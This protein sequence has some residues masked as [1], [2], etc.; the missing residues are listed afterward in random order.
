MRSN[1]SSRPPRGPDLPGRL[2]AAALLLLLAAACPAP[3]ADPA[4]DAPD[5]GAQAQPP[6][7]VQTEPVRRGT[8]EETVRGTATVEAR[9]QL[10][11][12][13][14]SGGTL[15]RVLVEEGDAVQPGQL[16]AEIDNPDLALTRSNAAHLVARLKRELAD[17]EP[18]VAKGYAPRQSAD[19][20][21]A[22]L[23]EAQSQLQRA[24]HQLQL[25]QVR[26]GL[27]G[28]VASRSVQPGQ[29]IAPGAALFTLVDPLHLQASLHVAADALAR[30][31]EGAP[32]LATVPALGPEHRFLGS[33]RLISPVVN[34]QTGTVKLT[35][36]LPTRPQLDTP[37]APA[38]RP[39]LL[40]ELRV[41]TARRDDALLAPRRAITWEENQPLVFV[42]APDGD[43]AWTARRTRV[44]LGASADD[45]VEITQGLSEGQRLIVVGQAGLKDGTPVRPAQDTPP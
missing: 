39:G 30:L 22:Q 43:D 34:P 15:R 10:L 3:G 40:A 35:V 7:P 20:L 14:E 19:E 42:A 38:L 1:A 12:V 28:V 29:Q 27:Q 9:H 45:T 26:A 6:V 2:A 44:T 4:E 8:A 41:V 33:V 32:V 5:A 16:L 17:L 25:L 24:Q 31:R 13:A 21:R 23:Q 37:D 36:D 18:L 11:L